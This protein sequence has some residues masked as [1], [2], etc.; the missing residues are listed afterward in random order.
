MTNEQFEAK[1]AQMRQA[2]K[3]YFATKDRAYLTESKALER[4]IDKELE[5]RKNPDTQQQLF[6][7]KAP[8]DNVEPPAAPYIAFMGFT[9]RE[10]VNDCTTYVFFDEKGCVHLKTVT[11]N[12]YTGNE[13]RTTGM[14]NFDRPNTI[15]LIEFLNRMSG[16]DG[17]IRT[18]DRKPNP[19]E[20]ELIEVSWQVK[21]DPDAEPRREYDVFFHDGDRWCETWGGEYSEF[22]YWRPLIGIDGKVILPSKEENEE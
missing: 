13:K 12:E 15:A 16:V 3:N 5:T 21:E 11:Q 1:V 20:Q 18:A 8:T 6:T 14:M 10:G 19:E 7:V 17:W 22:D 2:Q 9:E 4:E